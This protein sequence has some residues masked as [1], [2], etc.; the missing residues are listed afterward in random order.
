M[1]NQGT[2]MMPPAE[3]TL[4]HEVDALYYFIYYVSLFFF[5]LI[6]ACSLYFVL[7]FRRKGK[8]VERTP[9]ISHNTFLEI[10]WTVVPTVILAIIF[11]WGF[12]G[13]LKLTIVPKDA[14]QIKVTGQR[15]FWSFDYPEGVNSLNDMVVPVGKPIALLMSSQDVIHSFFVP[16][17]RIKQ[18]VLPNRYTQAWFEAKNVG[19]YDLLC[20]EFCGTQ[21]SS[22]LGKVRV[23]STQDYNRWLEEAVGSLGAGMPLKDL[24]E[25]LYTSKQCFTCHSLDGTKIQGPSFKG[26]FGSEAVF[27]DGSKRTV[28]ENYLRESILNP[29]AKV[30]AGYLPVMPTYQSL[31][32]EREVDALVEFIKS[33]KP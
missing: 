25:K 28:D 14:L 26:R 19:E 10:L 12:R 4:A 11:V 22:M 32:K 2:F 16:A 33:L 9:D 17:F 15:W 6:V 31:L 13:Y 1:N 18:D 27:T 23:V 29:Q 24:G 20:A 3:S 7:R 21:H 5:V 8:Q 30:V